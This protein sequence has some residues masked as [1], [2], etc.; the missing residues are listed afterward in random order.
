MMSLAYVLS[1]IT[2]WLAVSP[3]STSDRKARR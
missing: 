1:W 3:V 2:A